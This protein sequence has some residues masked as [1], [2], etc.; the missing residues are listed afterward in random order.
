MVGSGNW[1]QPEEN[2]IEA[3]VHGIKFSDGVEFDL[4]MDGDGELVVFHDEFVSG[5]RRDCESLYRE[6]IH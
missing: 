4:R 6:F 5:R 3:L 2:S 1:R